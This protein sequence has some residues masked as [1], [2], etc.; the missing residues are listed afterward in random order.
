MQT[1]R[2]ANKQLSHTNF[3]F[4]HLGP[5]VVQGSS[6]G[7]PKGDNN[8]EINLGVVGKIAA[9]CTVKAADLKLS[10]LKTGGGLSRTVIG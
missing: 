2:P 8:L 3:V 7:R 5:K 1:K 4:S 6:H 10:T 9:R